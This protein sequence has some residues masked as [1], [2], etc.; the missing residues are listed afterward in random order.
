MKS[1]NFKIKK[2]SSLKLAVIAFMLLFFGPVKGY[3]QNEEKT[4]SA[5]GVIERLVGSRANEFQLSID[6]NKKVTRNGLKLRQ[7]I[8]WSR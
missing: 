1:E 3:C 8:I 2:S 4:K 7:R 5:F 6:E